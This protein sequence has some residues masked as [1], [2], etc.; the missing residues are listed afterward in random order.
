MT[1]QIRA[2]LQSDIDRV[3]AIELAAHRAPWSCAILSDCVLVGYDCRVLEV[4][5]GAGLEIAS[6][7]ISRY[8]DN[9]CHVLN[10]C[11]TPAL[12]GKGYGK[13][14]LQDVINLP[15]KESVDTILLE[16]RP[17]NAAALRLYQK[18]GFEQVAM[19]RGYYRDTDGIED[20]VVLQ[21]RI[22]NN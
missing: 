11:V 18:M 22:T 20:A 1:L 5:T 10:L 9:I 4:D 21:K 6:Y 2:M 3:Y 15:A 16:V 13:H 19:K 17:S 12:Q 7:I 8:N 14:L